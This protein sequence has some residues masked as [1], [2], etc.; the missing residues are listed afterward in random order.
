VSKRLIAWMGVLAIA[1][2]L[3][4]LIG[5][6]AQAFIDRDCSDFLSQSAAQEFFLNSGGPSSDPHLLDADGDGRACEGLPCPCS[7]SGTNQ[8]PTTATTIVQYARIIRVIDGDT[9]R[10]RLQSGR[11]KTVRMLGIDSPEVYGT[12]VECYARRASATLKRRAPKGT[13]VKL[14]S[15]TTQTNKDRY[16]RLLR[17]VIKRSNGV[18]L[19]KKQVRIGSAQVYYPDRAFKR[20]RA[21]RY[22]Q[23]QA[24][25]ANLGLWGAC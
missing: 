4:I 9:V 5:T 6:P 11:R 20:N 22:A 7:S 1:G 21:Y 23:S 8:T 16:G 13:R 12:V 17:Y 19:N 15:D 25:S 14:I 3:V 24:I 18:D 2:S 10:V